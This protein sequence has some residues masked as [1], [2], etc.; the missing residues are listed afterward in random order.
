MDD[1][2][3]QFFWKELPIVGGKFT[4]RQLLPPLLIEK[5]ES[6]FDLDSEII[7][8]E[9]VICTKLFILKFQN[10]QEVFV[11]QDYYCIDE[12]FTEKKHYKFSAYFIESV[13]WIE[14]QRFSH[15]ETCSADK[16]RELTKV[17]KELIEGLRMQQSNG[18]IVDCFGMKIDKN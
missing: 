8:F 5:M 17:P 2:Y 13:E 10:E 18:A 1:H 15:M 9:N 16:L 12:M 11:A 14:G 6:I 4:I 7:A 3:T